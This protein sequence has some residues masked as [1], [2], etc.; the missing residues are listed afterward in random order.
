MAAFGSLRLGLGWSRGGGVPSLPT[1][2]GLLA[3]WDFSSSANLALRADEDLRFI[4]AASDLSGNG[5]TISNPAAESQALWVPGGRNGRGVMRHD[6]MGDGL[7]RAAFEGGPI[8]QPVLILSALKF[9]SDHR[10]FLTCDD[11]SLNSRRFV[12]GKHSSDVRIAQIVGSQSDIPT[13]AD[14]AGV[15]VWRIDIINSTTKKLIMAAGEASMTPA[16]GSL[17]GVSVGANGSNFLMDP[18]DADVG[19]IAIWQ[20][21]PSAGEIDALKSYARRKWG[22]A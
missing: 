12:L 19:E 20:H 15:W 4:E 18:S 10:C 22:L 5:N 16:A 9:P 14:V 7:R 21:D 3:H 1:I 13:L 11:S 17:Y 2:A 6:G 8:A